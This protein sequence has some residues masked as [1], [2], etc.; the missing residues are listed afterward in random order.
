M[1]ERYHGHLERAFAGSVG[2]W[3][4]SQASSCTTPAKH[5]QVDEPVRDDNQPCEHELD[6]VGEGIGIDD[7]DEVVLDEA[8]W[9]SR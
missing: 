2:H 4:G 3:L 5:G 6:G 9:I 8:T 1:P 7:G